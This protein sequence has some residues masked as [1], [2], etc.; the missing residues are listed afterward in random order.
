MQDEPV[1]VRI[2]D[3]ILLLVT[4]VDKDTDRRIVA[5]RRIRDG[6]EEGQFLN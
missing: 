6:E 5:A 2:D 1:D 4:C 3:Q